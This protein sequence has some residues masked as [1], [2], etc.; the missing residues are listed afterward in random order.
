MKTILLAACTAAAI[1]AAGS[2]LAV[3]K[4]HAT[5]SAVAPP[6]QPIPYAELNA[7]L[8]ASPAQRAHKDWWSGQMAS[9]GSQANASASTPAI[10]GD[11]PMN[12]MPATANTTGPI[13]DAPATPAEPKAPAA[14][15][16]PDKTSA[17]AAAP[18]DK[19]H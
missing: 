3:T 4:H 12:T 5:G 15:N 13:P 2:A 19:P 14:D 6:K 9:T 17:P 10:P 18:M 16:M 7:Y 8:K 11:T 1:L